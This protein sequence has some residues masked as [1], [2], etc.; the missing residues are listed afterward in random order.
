MKYS[1]WQTTEAQFIKQFD[2]KTTTKIWNSLHHTDKQGLPEGDL[3]NAWILFHNGHFADAAIAAEKLGSIATAIEIRSI[4]AYTDYICTDDELSIE[5]LE[6]AF[7]LGEQALEAELSDDV[8]IVFSTALAMGRYSQMISI[9]K[10]LR[11]GLGGKIKTLL[12][13]TLELSPEHTEAHTAMGLYHAEIIDKIGATIGGLTYG[14]SAKTAKQHLTTSQK[15]SPNSAITLIEFGNGLI[16]LDGDKSMG[17]ATD[18]YE[19][20]AQCEGLDSLQSMDVDFAA[21]QIE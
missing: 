12:G 19:L 20:A 7:I 15:L 2:L 18:L 1:N 21:S 3:L 10:A 9:T 6:H 16:L 13:K 11:K 17:K 4:V 5:L 8:N 14:A